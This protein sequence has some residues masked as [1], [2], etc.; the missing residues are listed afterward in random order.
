MLFNKNACFY[1]GLGCGGVGGGGALEGS[2]GTDVPLSPLNP[3]HV[4]EKMIGPFRIFVTHSPTRQFSFSSRNGPPV[5]ED[6][7]NTI[8]T[9]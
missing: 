6:D 7:V 8:E 4:E 3:E 9:F 5:L 1:P 2:F